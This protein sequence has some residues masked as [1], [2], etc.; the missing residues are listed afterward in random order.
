MV[1]PGTEINAVFSAD[2]SVSGSSGCNTYS[3]TYSVDAQ[4]YLTIGPLSVTQQMCSEPEGIM[5][6]E[7]AYLNLFQ[8][9]SGYQISGTALQIFSNGG[10][11]GLNY[12]AQ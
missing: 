6:Q 8:A 7:Q 9:A 10:K 1:L 2:G 12:Q 4:N 3:G 11:D 5:D